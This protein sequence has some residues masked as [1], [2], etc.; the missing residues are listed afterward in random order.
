MEPA[1]SEPLIKP[2]SLT[3]YVTA[4]VDNNLLYDEVIKYSS[5]PM[6]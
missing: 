6:Q 3:P 2:C 5:M 1:A 4:Y